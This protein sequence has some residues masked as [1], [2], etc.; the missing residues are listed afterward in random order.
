MRETPHSTRRKLMWDLTVFST[1]VVV[2]LRSKNLKNMGTI[3]RKGLILNQESS[4]T[5]R[6]NLAS[7]T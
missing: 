4:E 7:E 3:R 2:R 6:S 5:L 1:H